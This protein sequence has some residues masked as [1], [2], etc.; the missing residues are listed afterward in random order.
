MRLSVRPRSAAVATVGACAAVI[1]LGAPF[2][3]DATPAEADHVMGASIRKQETGMGVRPLTI[4]AQPESA[5]ISTTQTPGFDVSH[6]QG[7]IDWN[8]VAKSGAKFVYIK[9]TEGVGYRDSQFNVNYTD[10]HKAGF[11]R[12]A[13]HYGRPDVSDGAAQANYFVDHGGGWSRDGKTLPGALDIEYGDASQGG[14]CYGLD[15]NGMVNWIKAFSNQYHVRTSRWPVIYTSTKWWSQCTG[16]VSD[17][18]S[19]SPLWLAR[20]NTLIGALPHDWD[21]HTIWQF[22]NSGTFPGDQ[23]RFNGDLDRIRA[24]ANG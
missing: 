16:D 6:Y 21:V 8:S 12:G 4:V 1:A 24:L 15:T 9:A 22:A 3:T 7:T 18:S 13:Y 19:N 10:S 20:Y 11:I 5:E 14:P 17:F 23:D 2:P